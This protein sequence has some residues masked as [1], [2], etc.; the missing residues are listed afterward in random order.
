VSTPNPFL[1]VMGDEQKPANDNPF[2]AQ[3]A[4]AER[5]SHAVGVVH[6]ATYPGDPFAEARK[7][8]PLTGL[9]PDVAMRNPADA[10]RR[11]LDANLEQLRTRSPASST[12]L[13][14][15][16]QRVSLAGDQTAHLS[17]LEQMMG[18]VNAFSLLSPFGYALSQARASDN[19]LERAGGRG[20]EI[21][22]N[23]QYLVAD[24]VIDGAGLA[25]EGWF[26]DTLAQ[27]RDAER[28]AREQGSPK[29][30]SVAGALGNYMQGFL[31]LRDQAAAVSNEVNAM[32]ADTGAGLDRTDLNYYTNLVADSSFDLALAMLSGGATAAAGGGVGTAAWVGAAAPGVTTYAQAYQQ[33]RTEGHDVEV[34]Q[35]TAGAQAAIE[36]LFE[37][38]G[39]GKAFGGSTTLAKRAVATTG[40]EAL[41]EAA[42][43]IGQ[44]L[45]DAAITG[46]KVDLAELAGQTFD[47]AVVGGLMG[48]P[49][50]VLG[51]RNATEAD[52]G[53]AQEKLRQVLGSV[54]RAATLN[55]LG[56]VAADLKLAERAPDQ[57]RDLVEHLVGDNGPTHVYVDAG[58]FRTLYQTES[59]DPQA[60][61]VELTGDPAAYALALHSGGDLAIPIGAY[62]TI[63]RRGAVGEKLAQHVR[64]AP[65]D[66]SPAEMATFRS[67]DFL[68]E[69][70][71]TTAAERAK[72][73][74]EPLNDEQALREDVLGQLLGSGVER[75]AAEKYAALYGHVFRT[76]SA[77]S[78]KS[79]PQLWQTYGLRIQRDTAAGRLLARDTRVDA[80]LDPLI[81]AA[82]TGR[83]PTDREIYGDSMLQAIIRAG[84]INPDSIGGGDLRSQD[85]NRRPGL[86]NL[87]GRTVEAMGE[88][89]ATS[90]FA[91]AFTTLDEFNRPDYRELLSLIHDEL[92]GRRVNV[93]GDPM[94][95]AFRNDAQRVGGILREYAINTGTDPAT[96][97]R[98][99]L[100]RL[101]EEGL[102]EEF[103]QSVGGSLHPD[104]NGS[105][106]RADEAAARQLQPD[107]KLVTAGGRAPRESWAGRTRIT[108]AGGGPRVVYRGSRS[109][110][111]VDAGAF[112]ELGASTGHPTAAL[113]VWLTA[114][115][116][117]AARYGS[118]G[119]HF[120]DLRNPK[121]Y[122]IDDLP[123][124][125]DAA[126]YAKLR[127]TLQAAGHDGVVFDASDVG[128]PVQYV[129]FE[130]DAVLSREKPR[131]YFQGEQ[132]ADPLV[133]L[134]NLTA[135]N[136]VF[137]DKLGGLP[138][139]SLGIA[140][141]DLPFHGFGE[142][143]LI[144]RKSLA[145]P[146]VDNPVFS[147][148]A[149]TQRF[150]D[151]IW[152]KVPVKKAQAFLDSFGEDYR[153]R[154]LGNLWDYLVNQPN[155][156]NAVHE[157]QK[158]ATMMR[159]WLRAQGETPVDRVMEKPQPPFDWVTTPSWLAFV[160]A[161]PEDVRNARPGEAMWPKITEA[162]HRAIEERAN[163][164]G[165]DDRY[166]DRKS[167]QFFDSRG[168]LFPHAT[169]AIDFVLLKLDAP[170]QEDRY[171]SMLALRNQIGDRRPQFEAWAAAKVS[172]LFEEPR[173][174]VGRK[175]VPLTLENVVAAMTA[176]RGIAGREKSLTFGT[177]KAAAANAKRFRTLAE[178]QAARAQ[179]VGPD[180]HEA[181]KTKAD[182]VLGR[183]QQAV[184][185]F[186]TLTNWKGE[187][188]T[189]ESLDASMKVLAASANKAPTA[190]NLR[191][192]LARNGFRD[193][194]DAGIKLAV[195]A[196]RA[197]RTVA[198]D[199]L[200]AK[201][202]RAVS[203]REFAGAVIPANTAPEARAVLERAGIPVRE[204]S[205]HDDPAARR[206]AVASFARELGDQVL[207]QQQGQ[208][209]GSINIGADRSIRINLF[210]T[211]NLSTFLHESGHFFL[212]VMGDLASAPDATAQLQQ[213]YQHVL[214]WF[215]VA[216]RS[217]IATEQHEQFARGFEAYLRE[218][219][220]PAP[221]LVSTFARFRAWLVSI[222]RELSQL[223][224]RLTD[225]VRGVFDRLVATDEEIEAAHVQQGFGPVGDAKTLGLSPTAQEAYEA[226][227]RDAEEEARSTVTAQLLRAHQR[228][229]MAWWKQDRDALQAE[230]DA[231][232]SATPTYRALARLKAPKGEPGA[233]KLDRA[234]LVRLF[235][236]AFVVGRLRGLYAKSGGVDPGV[237]AADVGF[238][239]AQGMVESLAAAK[240][241]KALARA[242]AEDKMRERHP[243]PMTDGTLP[244]RAMEAAH[245]V[246]RVAVLA[247]E[248]QT[249]GK[250]AGS[251]PPRGR[252]LAAA[253]EAEVGRRKV[254][255]VRPHEYLVAERKAARTAA[256]EAAAGKYALAYQA[257][258]AE[259]LNAALY[260]AAMQARE[261]AEKAQALG[262]ALAETKAQQRIGKA[263]GTWLEQV[264]AIL[265]QYSFAR[266]P[267]AEA[268]R[269]AAVAAALQAQSAA[270]TLVVPPAV[271]AAVAG[272]VRTRWDELTVEE[273]RGV[274]DTLKQLQHQAREATKLRNGEIE[275]ERA[276]VDHA[277]AASVLAGNAAVPPNT[278]DRT[279]GEQLRTMWGEGRAIQ[280]TASDIARELDGFTDGGAVWSHTVRVIREAITQ[281]LNPALQA[282]GE[283][284]A[285]TY[286]RHFTKAELRTLDDPVLIPGI[287]G[288]WSRA[289]LLSLALNWGNQGNREA[290]LRQSRDK[291]EPAQVA[292]LLARLN[293][294]DWAFVTDV[295]EQVNS[296]WPAIAEAQRR[297]TG[298]APEK[299][300]AEPFTVTGTDGTT[301]TLPGGYF[302]LRFKPDSVKSMADE[303]ADFYEAIRTGRAARAATRRGHTIERVGSGGRTVLLELRVVDAHLRDV[304]RDL[305]LGEPV[306]YVHNVL[307]GDEFRS[308]VGDTGMLEHVRALELWLKDAAAGEIAP[309]KFYETFARAVRQNFTASVLAYKV[310]SAALQVTGIAQTGVVLGWQHTL[311]GVQN[312]LRKPLAMTR[313][314]HAH[315][316]LMAQRAQT[317]AEAVQSVMDARN[318]RVKTAHAT[319]IRWGYWMMGRV[320]MTVDIST[321]L[322]A[323]AAGMEKFD[324]DVAAARAYADDV[325]VRAQGS[326]E[327]TDKTPVQRGTLSEGVRQS[328]WIKA[329]TMLGGYM[330]AKGNAAY[331]QTRKTNF[332]SPAQALRWS[333]N[334]VSLF[335]VEGMIAAALRGALPDD[336]DDDGY[337]DDLFAF[338]GKEG[339]FSLLGAFPGLNQVSPSL[340]GYDAGGVIGNTAKTMYRWVE[341]AKQGEMDRAMRRQ[342]VN[343][344]GIATG[345]P[346]GQINKT[347]DAIDD[348]RA[349]KDTSPLEYAT[350][351]RR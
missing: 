48:A 190:A 87:E 336:E 55:A 139:P 319:M 220:A 13:A 274:T 255:D 324:N 241:R 208:A 31:E 25:G 153:E 251:N 63:G 305:H 233:A 26:R 247:F 125:E 99:Q 59:L 81:D 270:G 327:F 281:R 340:R 291:L 346:A 132:L 101:V 337:A 109:P 15:D 24:R 207:F 147:T 328:E 205:E 245:S 272:D 35:A 210:E 91:D 335:I 126:D 40:R 33:A 20:A 229:A 67:E 72:A 264:N 232:L 173:I 332:K 265:G 136:L 296:H 284:L 278:G 179:I 299:V 295:W 348:A 167:R 44:T 171:A 17:L 111:V 163:T 95:L 321:W 286:R 154:D 9:A 244:E 206:D 269:R 156:P 200:E 168:A 312:Y 279:R 258:R 257:K 181:A 230:I 187:I 308:A 199:Y 84:G 300:L 189:W 307:Q 234:A 16:P 217:E 161:N 141:A 43:T 50:A 7:Q 338:A 64:A 58:E 238:P 347:L 61:A 2:A 218:G 157:A 178:I 77:R 302:P 329:T 34:A 86:L 29:L 320:Q 103:M 252:V 30:A 235:G 160:R 155:Q 280:G 119:E 219:K 214:D 100:R 65:E 46:K 193:V 282:E 105:K 201:P 180:A 259:A 21:V 289:R 83:Y 114:S 236:D 301:Y 250:L 129:A 164:P 146:G 231:E 225:E 113:G 175:K 115:P 239:S 122:T 288:K 261:D 165:V 224:V 45:S 267:R 90:G 143:T 292:E 184:L 202:Q 14:A 159:A 80:A 326:Q 309:R 68:G 203:L 98:P 256:K 290:I 317:A 106:V 176:G 222:Y 145:E 6:A 221:E 123:D 182:A 41:G 1:Q 85:A 262:L 8:A 96:L 349:G 116:E 4:D 89:L 11:V 49:E 248:L 186:S 223:Q 134:H 306:N 78:G 151:L 298:L 137:A 344:L 351:P 339:A 75:S 249:L 73:S 108:R 226:M 28:R 228:E 331:E 74:T 93:G 57:A 152:S 215:G 240:P 275:L 237:F 121:V 185:P 246:K 71:G 314:V 313:Y 192:A 104:E 330:L 124:L 52:R 197:L 120:L 322:A 342:T 198:A 54:H 318:G 97:P 107:E 266:I 127:R 293:G 149:W 345:A 283:K 216:D 287:T 19:F 69:V 191:A 195:E 23:L 333:A 148:D 315:S 82:L 27:Y 276:E 174:E 343:L 170:A 110:G 37:R 38:Y 5:E 211:W 3:L 194:D 51:T 323:E 162:M 325:V 303:A 277:L 297:R 62:L 341:Q 32:R 260:R 142:I 118:V 334:M 227:L 169:R 60:A 130:P 79:I 268:V 70:L 311:A 42:T 304:L 10:Q 102:G 135:E 112:A 350:G 140:K 196:L 56:E 18:H 22:S 263:G 150:P 243:D 273:L 209:R 177:G 66:L 76:L 88:H 128:G 131:E 117:D 36:V 213:D 212:E 271:L 204:V 285:E 316:P 254:R 133:V 12:W 188:D 294:N 92:G 242:L 172:A 94:L 183:Y 53:R 47:S 158:S 39:L 138:V 144:G 310:S 253:A 166:S